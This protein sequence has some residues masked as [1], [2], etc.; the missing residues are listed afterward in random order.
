MMEIKTIGVIGAGQMGSA[1]AQVAAMSGLQVIMSDIKE[2]ITAT[3]H[4]A[5]LDRL[6]IFKGSLYASLINFWVNPR[7]SFS[8]GSIFFGPG[9]GA[10]SLGSSSSLA[11]VSTAA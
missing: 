2:I 1:I 8:V 5:Q 4:P 9:R 7:A 3:L 11:T 10:G 6:C